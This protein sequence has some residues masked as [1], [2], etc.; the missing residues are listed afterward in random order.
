VTSWSA[1]P[2][3]VRNLFNPAF[4]G[5]LLMRALRGFEEIDEDGMPFSLT[6]LVLPL[7]LHKDSREVIA[8]S[9]R[10]PLLKIVEHNP[11]LLVGLPQRAESL[12]PFT[13]EGLGLTMHLG[14]FEV[15]PHGRLRSLRG[16]R[17]SLTGTEESTSCQ[18]VARF[19]GKE[20]GRVADRATVFT[21]FGVRP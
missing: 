4:C 2:F 21:T 16:A 6:L 7:C 8:D 19:I 5:L 11:V 9:P 13:L 10:S 18:R 12:L 1:R 20:F 3:E 17:K 15:T 14:C